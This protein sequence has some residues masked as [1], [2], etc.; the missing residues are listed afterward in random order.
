MFDP[1]CCKLVYE[2]YLDGMS[3]DDITY[4]CVFFSEYHNI[5]NEDVNEIIDLMNRL[6]I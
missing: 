5:R 1:E 2:K 3:V 6:F 4:Y